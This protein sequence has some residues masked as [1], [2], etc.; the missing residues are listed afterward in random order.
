MKLVDTQAIELTAAREFTFMTNQLSAA[1][2]RNISVNVIGERLLHLAQTVGKDD[3]SCPILAHVCFSA[4]SSWVFGH[5]REPQHKILNFAYEQI[6]AS[7]KQAVAGRWRALIHKQLSTMGGNKVQHEIHSLLLCILICIGWKSEPRQTKALL[8]A[9]LTRHVL[10]A[11]W[12]VLQPIV[13]G[14]A[15]PQ[16]Q[17]PVLGTVELGL[18]LRNR[19]GGQQMLLKPRVALD[20]Q[21]S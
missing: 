3:E 5:D 15:S 13:D 18:A 16:V 11:A 20:T 4:I 7:E 14:R 17:V 9:K 19:A 1:D 10:C 21:T 6:R 8:E 12:E 2:A